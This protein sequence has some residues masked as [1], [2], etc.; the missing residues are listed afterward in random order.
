M[1]K[2][3]SKDS[4]STASL[5]LTNTA[6]ESQSDCAFRLNFAS[7]AVAFVVTL[8]ATTCCSFA[9]STG[10]G[11]TRDKL[12]TFVALDEALVRGLSGLAAIAPIGL[13]ETGGMEKGLPQPVA[14]PGLGFHAV[15]II[16]EAA[17][18]ANETR[19]SSSSFSS[20][21]SS[22]S[23]VAGT[24]MPAGGESAAAVSL[25]LPYVAVLPSHH[26]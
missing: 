9:F 7:T 24:S 22:S 1:S 11:L 26:H 3:S 25:P 4:N 17:D 10:I 6:T 21:S 18:A 5:A 15:A 12:F 23:D 2:S 14:G 19:S 8:L 16:G 13:F 20:S